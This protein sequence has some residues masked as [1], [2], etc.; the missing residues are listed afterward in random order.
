MNVIN[1][2]SKASLIFKKKYNQSLVCGW[3]DKPAL[4]YLLHSFFPI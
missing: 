4:I 1:T 2:Q 3:E